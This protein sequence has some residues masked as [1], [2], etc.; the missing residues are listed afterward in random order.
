LLDAPLILSKQ[1]TVGPH[2]DEELIETITSSDYKSV[3]NLSHKG[4]FGQTY[5]P[6][7][8]AALLE[9]ESVEYHHFPVA[10]NR[11]NYEDM[12]TLCAALQAAPKPVYVHC[13]AGQRSLP[14]ALIFLA[15]KQKLSGEQIIR[16][17]EQMGVSFRAPM[18]PEFIKQCLKKARQEQESAAA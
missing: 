13:R 10:L 2:L 7:E 11:M 15:L 3:F 1:L 8:E 4:E 9:A 6:K 12:A 5:S 17:A 14:L 16:K 18:L